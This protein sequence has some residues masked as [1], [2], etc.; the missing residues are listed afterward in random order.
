MIE[1]TGVLAREYH[2]ETG[3]GRRAADRHPCHGETFF[4]PIWGEFRPLQAHLR[5]ISTHGLGLI[6]GRRMEPGTK[7]VVLLPVRAPEVPPVVPARV[8]YASRREGGWVLGCAFVSEL[9]DSQLNAVLDRETHP[10]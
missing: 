9:R 8:A 10:D 6:A 5:D 1:S 4:E 3:P 7:V 2:D